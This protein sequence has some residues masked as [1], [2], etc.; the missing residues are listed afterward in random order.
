MSRRKVNAPT[1]AVIEEFLTDIHEF[2]VEDRIRSHISL[3]AIKPGVVA[4]KAYKG[5]DL[6]EAVAW[7][8]KNNDAGY[9]VYDHVNHPS[10]L[11]K[12]KAKK[13]EISLI[14]AVH[15]DIDPPKG[16]TDPE[17]IEKFRG[18][19][20]EKAN[21]LVDV[22]PHIVMSG[23]GVQCRWPLDAPMKGTPTTR[24]RVEAVN[25]AVAYALGGD[26][27]TDVSRLLRVAGTVNWPSAK[28][29]AEG[30][31]PQMATIVSL[32]DE[33]A[34]LDDFA[35]LPVPPKKRT[36]SASRKD[37][38]QTHVYS[39]GYQPFT[40]AE[41]LEAEP[42][43]EL[44]LEIEAEEHPDWSGS[45][46][47]AS[48]LRR[49]IDVF[50]RDFGCPAA[51]L[52]GDEDIYRNLMEIVLELPTDG[53]LGEC[54][55]H[56]D[57]KAEIEGDYGKLGRE[58]VVSVTH[59]ADKDTYREVNDRKAKKFTEQAKRAKPKED[60]T[61]EVLSY[62]EHLKDFAAHIEKSCTIADFP[63]LKAGAAVPQLLTKATQ[64]NI[65]HMLD[66]AG[67][68]ARTNQMNDTPEYWPENPKARHDMEQMLKG[69][70]RHLWP[71][72]MIEAIKSGAACLGMTDGESVSKEL[73]R[74]AS[75]NLFHPLKEFCEATPWDKRDRLGAIADCIPSH[76]S[77]KEDY[78]RLFF[79]QCV[80]TYKSF[81]NYVAN[82]DGLMLREMVV[83]VSREQRLGKTLFWKRI[84][85]EGWRALGTQLQIGNNEVN[86]D[87]K[88]RVLG[89][90][91]CLLDEME[92]ISRPS[93]HEIFKNFLSETVDTYR[94]PYD[95]N[96]TV[97]PR[98][99][100]FV[101]AANRMS[102]TDET[103]STRLLIIPV[104]GRIDLDGLDELLAEEGYLQQ[105]YAQAWY[106]VMVERQLGY[107]T[108][109]QHARREYIN[110][111][112]EVVPDAVQAY[113]EHMAKHSSAPLYWL[114]LRQVREVIGATD[115]KGL[116]GYL[117]KSGAH[118]QLGARV[119][120]AHGDKVRLQKVYAIPVP[121]A[122]AAEYFA[123]T[124]AQLGRRYDEMKQD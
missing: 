104:T 90:M 77:L 55:R 42:D 101:G 76:S 68:V 50:C 86:K 84:I 49:C 87:S 56:A 96:D 14:M 111:E 32:A 94:A 98:T 8:A 78:I 37:Y 16:M 39:E 99:T 110:E 106:E 121:E 88:R 54:R 27:T 105:C 122:E 109:E 97:R 117:A 107:L 79:R 116:A 20:I 4:T 74:A 103:G 36:Q 3:V 124:D 48:F 70:A 95:R 44:D 17:E 112:Y 120:N 57:A 92:S 114:Q 113:Q 28:K 52:I 26:H 19:I 61:F 73:R 60:E 40:L 47:I 11:S 41:I 69:V 81:E 58:C 25:R 64:G 66:A 2:H 62:V 82:G 71:E 7:A 10:R 24:N 21:V 63:D 85:P 15:V 1:P 119:T 13:E 80:V 9:N 123:L 59:A 45:E 23:N 65:V 31:V 12:K 100:V 6:D 38:T 72:Q 67:I 5:A 93:S 102:L 91:A 75:R 118:F 51:D 29:E 53:V 43:F 18:E 30:R 33:F 34:T 46:Y 83:L 89:G 115:T 108:D 35:K 22:R